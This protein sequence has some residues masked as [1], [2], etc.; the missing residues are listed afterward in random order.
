[1]INEP[2][3]LNPHTYYPPQYSQ[4]K[5]I[6][7]IP[8]K[9]LLPIIQV[10]NTSGDA[11][12]LKN[13]DSKVNIFK[14]IVKINIKKPHNFIKQKKFGKIFEIIANPSNLTRFEVTYLLCYTLQINVN[15]YT[16]LT[17]DCLTYV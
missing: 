13:R 8:N 12:N 11:T 10:Y 1:M 7:I 6:H 3:K 17:N 16:L 4:E 2:T 9:N 14:V 15:I 5:N